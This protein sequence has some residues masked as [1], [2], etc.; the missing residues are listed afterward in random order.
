MIWAGSLCN[1]WMQRE[2]QIPAKWLE[3]TAFTTQALLHSVIRPAVQVSTAT[4]LNSSHCPK[5]L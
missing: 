3:T 5:P 1:F 2:T 4:T